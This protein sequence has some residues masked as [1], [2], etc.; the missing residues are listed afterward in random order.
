MILYST[1]VEDLT[2][3]NR[4]LAPM[5]YSSQLHAT[6]PKIHSSGFN[7]YISRQM[8]YIQHASYKHTYTHTH[9]HAHTH[10]HT[11]THTHKHTYTTTEEHL[12]KSHPILKLHITLHTQYL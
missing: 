7:M 1:A 10:T 6:P 12:E 4:F 3:L 8:Y 11:H 2:W 5:L 9:T